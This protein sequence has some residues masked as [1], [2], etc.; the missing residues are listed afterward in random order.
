MRNSFF[1]GGATT[2]DWRLGVA[3]SVEILIMPFVTR[4]QRKTA[5]RGGSRAIRSNAAT[6]GFAPADFLFSRRKRNILRVIRIPWS[7]H[8]WMFRHRGAPPERGHLKSSSKTEWKL[9]S[10][11][12]EWN[13]RSLN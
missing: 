12:M 3:V 6:A 7:P 2:N 13:W 8:Q 9:L 5:D 1:A 10:T 4:G 11:E